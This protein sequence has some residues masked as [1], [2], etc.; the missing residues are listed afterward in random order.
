MFSNPNIIEWITGLILMVVSLGVVVVVSYLFALTAIRV[1][2]DE[3][4][5]P[6]ENEKA[7]DTV[8]MPE[9]KRTAA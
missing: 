3:E 4:I 2:G 1:L 9:R 6:Q 8:T 7:F 5:Q